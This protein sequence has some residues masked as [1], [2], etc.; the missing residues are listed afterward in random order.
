MTVP[1]YSHKRHKS[2]QLTIERA[3]ESLRGVPSHHRAN[4][5]FVMLCRNREIEGVISS[6]RQVEDRFNDNY[7]YPWVF[8]NDEPFTEEFKRRVSVLIKSPVHFGVI[9]PDV[10]NQPDWIDEEKAAAGRKKMV[11]EMIIYGASRKTPPILTSNTPARANDVHASCEDTATCADST[12]EHELMLPYRYYWRIE[13][14][15]DYFCDL[16]Y[17]PFTYM[18]VNKKVYG[19]S[20]LFVVSFGWGG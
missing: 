13:P 4:A 9:P 19:A 1:K 11:E 7:G 2:M 18:E 12:R 16:N 10:W 3:Q 8:L 15:V 5:T 14:D 20:L 6:V 17:D